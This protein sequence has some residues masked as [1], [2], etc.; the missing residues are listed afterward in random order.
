MLGHK[1]CGTNF[2]MMKGKLDIYSLNSQR[3]NLYHEHSIVFFLFCVHLSSVGQLN[4]TQ[5]FRWKIG[6]KL[7][8][9]ELYLVSWIFQGTFYIKM[10]DLLTELIHP[11]NLMTTSAL[12]DWASPVTSIT[13]GPTQWQQVRI[14]S[15]WSTS[16]FI[17]CQ[18]TQV[19]SN[20]QTLF[21][22]CTSEASA[23]E[24]LIRPVVSWLSAS[25]KGRDWENMGSNP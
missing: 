1:N 12:T 18:N 6:R 11:S 10:E 4:S 19:Q 16:G 14:P 23:I 2:F 9:K 25:V 21:E 7:Q 22:I 13:R 3:I 8:R 17:H 24:Y 5:I 15:L 20:C